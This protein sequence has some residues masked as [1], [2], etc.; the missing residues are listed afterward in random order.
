M[1]YFNSRTILSITII[2]LIILLCEIKVDAQK[3]EFGLRFMPTFSNFDVKTSSGGTVSGE[4][5]L[6][7]GFG[8]LLGFNFSDHVGIQGEVIYSSA[9]QKY[10]DVDVERKVQ[11]RYV[12]I[13]L[14][15][16]LN[17]NKSKAVNLNIVA[18]PQIGIN[19]GSSLKVSG[20]DITTNSNGVLSIRKGD[21]GFAY[22]AGLDFGLNPS[23]TLRLG[24]GYR[25]VIGMF[26]ISDNS[27]NITTDRFY[28][29]D[30]SHIKS[31]AAYIGLS[32]LF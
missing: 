16:S 32:F 15:L 14:L 5:N 6:G 19:V 29:L 13:P 18:G 31:H 10:K 17:T 21:I 2:A 22:G 3:A 27:N 11:L 12:N 20:G 4:A 25:G 26:D 24:L 7:M 28:I 9:S 1:K 23:R 30:R 8:A